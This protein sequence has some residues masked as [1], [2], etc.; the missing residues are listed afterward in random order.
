MNEP[1]MIR[2]VNNDVELLAKVVNQGIDSRLE[3]FTKSTISDCNAY[4]RCTF[5]VHPDEM[6][7]MLRRLTELWDAG[8]YRAGMM[9]DDIVFILYGKETV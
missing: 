2:A 3:A 1:F 4:N 6:S 9:A 5:T 7:I 8:H